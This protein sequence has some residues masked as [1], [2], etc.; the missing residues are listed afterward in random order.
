[1]ERPPV[2]NVDIVRDFVANAHGNLERVQELL[3]QEPMLINAAWDWGGGDWETGLGAAAHMGKRRSRTI[4]WS[5]GQG[6]IFLQRPCLGIWRLSRPSSKR[7]PLFAM[8]AAP[9]A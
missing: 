5:K 7:F 4:F 1:M 6:W 2:L 3:Q 9:M 8:G